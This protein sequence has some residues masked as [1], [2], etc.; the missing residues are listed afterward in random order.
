MITIED[1]VPLPTPKTHY[2]FHEMEVG[3]SFFV[4]GGRMR[5]VSPALSAHSRRHPPKRFTLRVVDG[6]VRVWRIE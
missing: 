5:T 6:G 4:A 3:Q 2:P 1:D